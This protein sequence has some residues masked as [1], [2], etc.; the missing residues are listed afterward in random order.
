MLRIIALVVAALLC[1]QQAYADSLGSAAGGQAANQSS[2]A[3]CINQ[4]PTLS[5]GQQATL[6]CD[7]SGNLITASSI[8]TRTYV[9][10][11]ISTVTTGG[12]AVTAL[13]AGHHTAGGFLYN[14]IGASINL[15]IN[16]QGT[17]SGTTSAGA[18]TCVQP[19][20]AYTLA[21]AA[22]A[23]SVITSDSSHPFSGYGLN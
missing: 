14:P 3:G 19:G 4:T 9:P 2:G 10:L 15:C 13:N 20:Q 21:P 5:S 23:V 6:R 8:G 7:S 11:D 17:A 16:E 22:G 18:L 12:T 1:A